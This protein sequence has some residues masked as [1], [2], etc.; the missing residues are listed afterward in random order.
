[1]IDEFFVIQVNPFAFQG[2]LDQ[3]IL[4][5]SSS[6]QFPIWHHRKIGQNLCLVVTLTSNPLSASTIFLAKK[7]GMKRSIINCER[8][9]VSLLL[10]RYTKDDLWLITIS[11]LMH[12]DKTRRLM[13]RG[14]VVIM[15]I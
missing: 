11:V 7:N 8:L 15:C 10:G 13:F 14:L 12:L 2:L 3:Y 9:V 4:L 6:N 1:M 5:S